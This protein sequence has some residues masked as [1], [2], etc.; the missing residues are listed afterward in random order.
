MSG[1][2]IFMAVA[3]EFSMSTLYRRLLRL[4]SETNIH[5]TPIGS[6]LHLQYSRSSVDDDDEFPSTT[7]VSS[8]PSADLSS[9]DRQQQ[10]QQQ[11]LSEA[12]VFPYGCLVIWGSEDDCEDD[13]RMFMSAVIDDA[14]NP[15][16]APVVD[17]MQFRYAPGHDAS[18]RRDVITLSAQPTTRAFTDSAAHTNGIHNGCDALLPHLERMAISCGLAQSIK[19]GAFESSMRLTIERTRHLPEQLASTGQITASH[20]DLSRLMGLLFLDRYRYHLSGDLLVTPAFFWDNEAYYPAYKRVERYL[21]VS[22]RGDVLNKRVEVVQELYKLLG[23]EI[24]NQNSMALEMA[25]T[26]MIAFEILLTLVSLAKQSMQSVFVGFIL[27]FCFSFLGWFLWRLY[28]RRRST[29]ILNS[30]Q[31]EP[32]PLIPNEVSD[33]DIE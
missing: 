5:P 29:V 32:S 14:L 8:V 4:S 10:Q 12:F 31:R 15:R 21:E 27:F 18:V 1:D 2:V 26:V 9:E 6:V 20:R 11:Q 17:T 19:L 3:N 16:K 23:D 30:S 33:F 24:S 28:R 7:S 25:I 13:C 22:E